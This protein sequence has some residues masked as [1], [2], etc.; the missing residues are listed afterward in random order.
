[1]KAGVPPVTINAVLQLEFGETDDYGFVHGLI[2]VARNALRYCPQ[3]PDAE[4]DSVE[5][6]GLDPSIRRISHS[7]KSGAAWEESASPR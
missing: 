7:R 5:L 2:E 4:F 3:T 1:M 6:R